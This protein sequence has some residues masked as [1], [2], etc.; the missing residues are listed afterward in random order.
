M[1]RRTSGTWK[2]VGLPGPGS[3]HGRR[4]L[5]VLQDL[6]C[7]TSWIW[8]CRRSEGRGKIRS[9][10]K[11]KEPASSNQG[12]GVGD[13]RKLLQ[14]SRSMVLKAYGLDQLPQHCLRTCQ[15]YQ[16]LA[17]PRPT[18]SDTEWAEHSAYPAPWPTPMQAK[19]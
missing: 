7:Q 2:E 16:F 3:R 8:W 19:V 1:Q 15:A 17:H 11:V 13:A 18:D 9:L 14:H 12:R 10:V 4:L 6:G 5:W